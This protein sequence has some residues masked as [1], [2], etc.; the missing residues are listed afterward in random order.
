ML[1]WTDHVTETHYP[2]IEK[3]KEIGYHGIEI[4]LGQG[5][6]RHY[7]KLGNEIAQLDL[8]VTAVTSIHAN[9]NIASPDKK[10]RQAGLDQLRWAMDMGAA[11]GVKTI[12]GPFHSAFAHF[13]QKP[14]AQAERQWSAEYL[15]LAGGYASENGITL[16]V[17]A[18]N[19]FECYL[20]N[21]MG[22]LKMLLDQVAHPN[23]GAIYDSHHAHIEEKNHEGALNTIATHLKHVHI[24]ES[25]RGT[26]G[27]GQVHWHSVFN[28][29]Q[30]MGY[31]GWLTIEAFSRSA[32]EFANAINVWRDFSPA[33]EIITQGFDFIKK[34]WINRKP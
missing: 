23:V 17:E 34:N 15:H 33:E 3:L 28:T 2:I 10:I 1:L 29:L 31:D 8:E 11:L 20:Y 32:P 7:H 19:R 24:S 4:P 21:T 12:C 16:A 25:D 22:D 30:D 13:S 6:L 18:L 5:D 14:P 27:N 26:P 9:T